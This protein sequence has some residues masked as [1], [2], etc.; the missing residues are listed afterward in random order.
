MDE[1]GGRRLGR[2]ELTGST[3]GGLQ[4]GP[5]TTASRA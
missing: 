1:Y 5:S 2:D 4:Q 3:L